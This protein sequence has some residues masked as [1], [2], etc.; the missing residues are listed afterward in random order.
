MYSF[1]KFFLTLNRL[2]KQS[3][4]HDELAKFDVYVLK[5]KHSLETYEQILKDVN[6]CRL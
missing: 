1:K 6:K 2:L 4:F 3:D 5:E